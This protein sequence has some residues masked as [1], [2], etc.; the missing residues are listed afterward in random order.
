MPAFTY[1]GDPGRYYPELDGGVLLNPDDVVELDEM[2]TDGRFIPAPTK[3][4]K[5]TNTPAPA[6]TPNPTPEA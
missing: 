3:P 6:A 5:P 1:T 2:P 4:T